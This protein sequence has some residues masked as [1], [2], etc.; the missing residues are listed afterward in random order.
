MPI[1]I[2]TSKARTKTGTTL[3]RDSRQARA[4]QIVTVTTATRM[5]SSASCAQLGACGG[6]QQTTPCRNPSRSPTKAPVMRPNQTQSFVLIVASRVKQNDEANPAQIA[7]ADRR[8]D[9]DGGADE[10]SR[11]RRRDSGGDV[12][13]NHDVLLRAGAER[14][15]RW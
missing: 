13:R 15:H 7:A 4:A 3:R 8:E 1:A 9:V 2:P 14:Q 5:P 10:C 11:R 6:V 12:D